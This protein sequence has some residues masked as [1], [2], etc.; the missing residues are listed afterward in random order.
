MLWMLLVLLLPLGL[1]LLLV[2]RNIAGA[3]E[4]A[5]ISTSLLLQHI[6]FIGGG[7]IVGEDPG[8]TG[9]SGGRWTEDAE[10]FPSLFS[11]QAV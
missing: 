5:G 3:T 4:E 9:R 6:G 2:E 11:T 8:E 1:G 7:A 10:T